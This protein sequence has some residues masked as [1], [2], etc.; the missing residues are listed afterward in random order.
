MNK[1]VTVKWQV[2]LFFVPFGWIYVFER[3]EKLRKA[4]LI[5]LVG[6]LCAIPVGMVLPFPYGMIIIIPYLAM[7]IHYL[8]K[9][10]RLWNE[11]IEVELS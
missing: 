1:P 7:A 11:K 9:W 8:V 3:I 4:I 2:I 5:M 10:S 6:N